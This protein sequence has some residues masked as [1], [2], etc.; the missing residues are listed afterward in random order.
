MI[1]NIIEMLKISDFIGVS[2]NIEI[3]KGKHE[4]K[5]DIKGIWKQSIRELK[6]KRHGRKKDN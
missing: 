5:N 2:E 3:A 6:V 4:L 1:K